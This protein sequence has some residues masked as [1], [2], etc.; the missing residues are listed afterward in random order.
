M[1]TESTIE[2]L[3]ASFACLALLGLLH[4]AMKVSP[5]VKQWGVRLGERRPWVYGRL[6][7]TYAAAYAAF[8]RARNICCV[9]L[10]AFIDASLVVLDALARVAR[11]A[12]FPL[13]RI[14]FAALGVLAYALLAALVWVPLL[15]LLHGGARVVVFLLL[16]DII[17]NHEPTQEA[18]LI[19]NLLC[20]LLLL[21]LYEYL[22]E[23]DR[24]TVFFIVLA[25]LACL[26]LRFIL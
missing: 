9:P 17:A 11:A 16:A 1:V 10:D 20:S 6:R 23:G 7:A 13:A 22:D 14:F 25:G 15:A 8:I 4:I 3:V 19:L 26:L 21:R 12:L 24:L 5:L 2:A 18:L